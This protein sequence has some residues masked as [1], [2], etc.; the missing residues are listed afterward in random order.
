MGYWGKNLVRN[1][2]QLGALYAVCDSQKT[3]EANCKEQY[4]GVRFY[5]E[6]AAVLSDPEIDAVAMATPAVSHYAMAKAALEAGIREARAWLEARYD[7]GLPPFYEGSHWTA[8][9]FPE[10]VEE[11]MGQQ[12]DIMGSFA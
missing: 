1:F 6:Y 2:H 5:Q 4:G 12:F 10:L 9:V 7:A 8:P 11:K 3:V